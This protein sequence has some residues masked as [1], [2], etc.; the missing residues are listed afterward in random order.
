[1]HISELETFIIKFKQL[2]FCGLD[3]HLD[4]NPQAG[5]AWV[6]L[7]LRIGAASP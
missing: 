1:M 6:G 7:N 5:Q 4:V 2:W 3:A